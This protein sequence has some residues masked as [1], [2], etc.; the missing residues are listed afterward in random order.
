MI[1]K[2]HIEDLDLKNPRNDNDYKAWKAWKDGKVL[3]TSL[4]ERLQGIY[5]GMGQTKTSSSADHDKKT[6]GRYL[7]WFC[8]FYSTSPN[9]LIAVLTSHLLLLEAIDLLLT[10][11]KGLEDSKYYTPGNKEEGNLAAPATYSGKA[12]SKV[13]GSTIASPA[14]T[15]KKE[16]G[17]K[18]HKYNKG[19]PPYKPRNGLT[20]HPAYEIL[21]PYYSILH[22]SYAHDEVQTA[23]DKILAG[24]KY[25]EQQY[26]CKARKWYSEEMDGW[27]FWVEL[28]EST[29]R[30]RVAQLPEQSAAANLTEAYTLL[31]AWA[32]QRPRKEGGMVKVFNIVTYKMDREIYA[33]ARSFEWLIAFCHRWVKEKKEILAAIVGGEKDKDIDHFILPPMQPGD[34]KPKSKAK[35]P[36]AEPVA[37][38]TV[39]D[40]VQIAIVKSQNHL[41]QTMNQLERL[42][43]DDGLS[44]PS[45]TAKRIEDAKTLVNEL[46]ARIKWLK[47]PDGAATYINDKKK[48]EKAC[49]MS[50]TKA[51][52]TTT[53]EPEASSKKA[54]STTVVA[55]ENQSADIPD[56][57]KDEPEEDGGLVEAMP[58]RE[59]PVAEEQVKQEEEEDDEESLNEGMPY[60]GPP[61]PAD[62]VGEYVNQTM[63]EHQEEF[64]EMMKDQGRPQEVDPKNEWVMVLI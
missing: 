18:V 25:I 15:T 19:L 16:T 36:I 55:P 14:V 53:V 7:I 39:F 43:D 61:D 4:S 3:D 63:E 13:T 29:G 46:N 51:V 41:V 49:E 33:P 21:M 6:K 47:T 64:E 62:D 24:V 26:H 59:G 37:R 38:R 58:E 54:P 23:F 17:P 8:L 31:A 5:I 57:K 30:R 10:G 50:S 32:L 20:M 56:E 52:S 34:E 9:E 35:Q 44:D 1:K 48:R 11:H 27:I 60:P 42:Y 45:V 2:H 40:D 12:I 22:P 28:I